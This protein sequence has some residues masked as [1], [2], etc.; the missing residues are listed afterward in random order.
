[1]NRLPNTEPP[2]TEREAR[3]YY[4]AGCWKRLPEPKLVVVNEETGRGYRCMDCF[5]E[6]ADD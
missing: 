3:T 4:C 2:A 5:R 6:K 1:M